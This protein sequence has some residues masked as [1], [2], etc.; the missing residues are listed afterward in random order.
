MVLD[1]QLETKHWPEV[2]LPQKKGDR[3]NWGA[4]KG[5]SAALCIAKCA[6]VSDGPVLLVTNSSQKAHSLH[7]EI[8]YFIGDTLP[9][10]QFPDWE[11]LPYDHFSPH[12]DIVSERL[13]T[14]Y[15]LPHFKQGVVIVPIA[16]LAHRLVPQQFV[17]GNSFILKVGDCIQ[18]DD[19]RQEWVNNGYQAVSQVLGHGEFAIRGNLIDIFPMGQKE[20]IRIDLFDDEIESIRRFDVETQRSTTHCQDLVC[21]PAREYPFQ[22][23]DIARFRTNWRQV[24]SGDPTQ[25]PI[26]D[27]ISKGQ[28]TGGVEYYLPLFFEQ[29]QTL[30]DYLPDN[31][32]IIRLEAISEGYQHFWTDIQHRYEQYRHDTQRP[33]LPPKS[34]VLEENELFGLIKPHKQIVIQDKPHATSKGQNVNL[35]FESVP[36]IAISN[37]QSPLSSLALFLTQVSGRVLFCA[38]S[39]GRQEALIAL[40]AKANIRP[41][42]YGNWQDFLHDAKAQPL[43]IAVISLDQSTHSPEMGITLIAEADLYG[44]QVMQRRRRKKTDP[45]L[46]LQIKNLAELHIGHPVVHLEHGVGRYLGL[47]HL[48]ISD[49]PAEFLTIEYANKDKLYVPVSSLDLISQYSGTQVENAPLH[50]LGSDHWEKAKTKAQKK[51]R[52]VAA[53]LLELHAKRHSKEGFAFSSIVEDY[54]AFEGA[55]GFETTP[56]QQQ[57]IDQVF[58]DMQSCKPMDRLIC[59][60]VGFGKTEVALR[61]AF[62]AVHHQK[63]V[64]FLVPTTLLAQQHYETFCDRFANWP[65]SIE[66]LSR[67]KSKKEQTEVINKLK[68]AQVDIVIG[69]HKL[70][71]DDIRFK[72]LGLLIIDEEHRFGVRQKEKIKKLRNEVDIL[73][74]TATPIPRTLNMALST[75]RDLSIIA[76][77]PRKRLSVKT[78]VQQKNDTLI[79]EAITRELMRGG[80][81]YYLHNKVETIENTAKHL[82]KLCP[83]A[84]IIVAH[85]QMPE[86]KLEKVMSDFY[87]QRYHVLVCTTIIETGIDIPTA[88]TIIIDRA[89]T[90][91]LAQLHQLRG[92]VGRSHHQAYAYCLTRSEKSLS[93]DAKKRLQALE[94]LTELGSGFSLATHDL[95]IRGAGELLGDEQS[96]NINEVGFSLYM[97]LLERAVTSLK[98]GKTLSAD[99]PLLHAIE[100]DLDIP[101]LIPEDYIPDVHTRLILYKR[102]ASCK[103]EKALEDLQVEMIDRFGLLPSLIKNLFKITVLKIKARH[104]NIIKIKAGKQSGQVDFDESPNVSPDTIINIMRERP[105]HFKLVGSQ[106]F[107]FM[108]DMDDIETRYQTVDNLLNKLT[109]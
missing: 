63:Q 104:L 86:R 54:A 47:Q 5:A 17:Q 23:E 40:L 24:F 100:I 88:N 82:E 39:P 36:N 70:I 35:G 101:A 12:Q 107:K 18:I 76:T 79:Q 77:P 53:E 26:Y 50:R 7:R 22:E 69:T 66:V 75:I 92:R 58:S 3:I 96:G 34:L 2:P 60:D 44:H 8:R 19:K 97:E 51:A 90:F 72:N 37:A 52:D 15:E 102:I 59:G 62:L 13:K 49:H 73:T 1:V 109:Q 45:A 31:T 48:Q 93:N 42:V 68:N 14:L 30:F 28:S 91:G 21:L 11:I 29:M 20:P 61:A 74:L 89:D 33:I 81:T 65:V 38:E 99:T 41:T 67:F 32:T 95:E 98:E 25:C 78:F 57:A 84:K 10:F 9:C 43:G 46:E 56:D 55:F 103:N 108:F 94:S 6:E 64:C 80:Q 16:T 4:C 106:S 105:K 27:S 85:G 83:D 71:Q 87:H